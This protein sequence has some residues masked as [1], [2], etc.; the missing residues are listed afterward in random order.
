MAEEQPAAA[1]GAADKAAEA[2]AKVA[3]MAEGMKLPGE[4]PDKCCWCFPIKCGMI[5][6]GIFYVL[7][8]IEMVFNVL[9]WFRWG[10]SAII[11]AILYAICIVPL[12]IGSVF[13]IKWFMKMGDADAKAGVAK[14][15]FLMV[16]SQV[17]SVIV[18]VL[19]AVIYDG[20]TFGAAIS[21]LISAVINSL[22]YLYYAAASKRLPLIG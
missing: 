17:L 22:L 4:A 18:A 7:N 11:W 12:V 9:D 1:A 5:T 10:P 20:Y 15:C 2:E 19:A 8:A 16:V 3:K 13:F 21:V 14:A 6:I